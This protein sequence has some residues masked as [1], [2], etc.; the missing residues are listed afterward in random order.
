MRISI[1]GVGL[2]L[3]V[4]ACGS[5]AGGGD[6]K[7]LPSGGPTDPAAAAAPQPTAPAA[8][9][10]APRPAAAPQPAAAA[11]S[12]VEDPGFTLKLVDAGPYKAGELGRFVLQL[13]PHGVYHINQEYPFEADVTSD[14]DTA[15]PKAKFEKPDAAE[16]GEH[17]ARWEVPFTAKSAGDHPVKVNVKF[18]VCTKENCVP[19]ERNLSLALAVK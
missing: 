10:A 2:G 14:A 5:G 11:A 1:L 12:S 15:L 7:E 6:N 19:D 9:A 8:P 18:A 13:E 17:K 3:L 16:F 4:S